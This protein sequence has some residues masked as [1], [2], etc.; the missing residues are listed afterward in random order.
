MDFS[1][2]PRAVTNSYKSI[3]SQT[4][5]PTRVA[6]QSL[7]Q[8]RGE[9]RYGQTHTAENMVGTTTAN[10]IASTETSAPVG[11]SQPTPAK[12][13]QNRGMGMLTNNLEVNTSPPTTRIVEINLRNTM[14]V[15][16]LSTEARRLLPTQVA[17]PPISLKFIGLKH[18]DWH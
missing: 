14:T 11:I 2:I 3:P 13:C 8:I 1:D 4:V 10:H 12:M 16:M 17:A 7:N 6:K 15:G 9:R 18:G 5:V